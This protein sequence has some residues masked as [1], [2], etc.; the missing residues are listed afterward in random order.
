[1]CICGVYVCLFPSPF[2]WDVGLAGRGMWVLVKR[3]VCCCVCAPVSDVCMCGVC[4]GFPH[5]L[6]V[7]MSRRPREPQESPGS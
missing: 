1:M 5:R 2:Y 3:C 6:A 4:R 7:W